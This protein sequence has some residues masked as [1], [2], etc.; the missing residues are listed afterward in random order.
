[1]NPIS[2]SLA[3]VDAVGMPM[4]FIVGLHTTLLKGN[5]GLIAEEAVRVLLDENRI[6]Y[7]SS[8]Q[9]FQSRNTVDDRKL[10]PPPAL[11]ERQGRK[12][13]QVILSN[14]P[15]FEHRLGNWAQSRLVLFDDAFST[16]TD[17]NTITTSAPERGRVRKAP[18][19]D[20][21]S[22]HRK[23]LI[24][25]RKIR[26]G[27]LNFFVGVLKSYRRYLIYGTPD[28][29]DPMVKFQFDY[30]VAAQPAES[31]PFVK[32]MIYSQAFTVFVDER[33]LQVRYC[34]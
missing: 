9:S 5:E 25:E 32:E 24:D 4:P 18:S 2:I 26:A 12:L 3:P 14:A 29:P 28:D 34:L 7:P 1:M 19:T 33:I 17:R 6:V 20:G 15:M 23:A 22:M 10:G 30:F 27:F 13:L 11:P 16:L 8:K 21:T 31:Q